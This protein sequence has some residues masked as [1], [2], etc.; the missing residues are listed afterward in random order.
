MDWSKTPCPYDGV[1]VPPIARG[2]LTLESDDHDM[3]HGL[4]Y[5]AEVRD[6]VVNR[7]DDYLLRA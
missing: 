6:P 1:P 4:Q 5:F 7:L 3:V 2:S